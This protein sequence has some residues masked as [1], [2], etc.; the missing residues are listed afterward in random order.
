MRDVTD[1]TGGVVTAERAKIAAGGWGARLLVLR[2]ST[3][4][5]REVPLLSSS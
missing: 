4:S 3:D 2:G 5:G 1:D